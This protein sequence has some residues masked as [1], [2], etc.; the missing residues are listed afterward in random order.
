MLEKLK[1]A[2]KVVGTRKLV[3]AVQAGEIAEAYLADDADLF[4]LRQVKDACAQANVRIVSVETMKA[5]GTA[6]GVEVP[7]AAAGVLK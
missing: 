3:R 2:R 1:N 5:L 7:T 4:I 6:C